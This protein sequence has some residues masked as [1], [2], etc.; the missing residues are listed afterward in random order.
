MAKYVF[1]DPGDDGT[2]VE[3]SFAVDRKLLAP[4]LG[5]IGESKQSIS[6]PPP[7]PYSMRQSVPIRSGSGRLGNGQSLVEIAPSGVSAWSGPSVSIVGGAKDSLRVRLKIPW[8][9][10]GLTPSSATPTIGGS[11]P[12]MAF[13]SKFAYADPWALGVFETV[14]LSPT[15]LAAVATSNFPLNFAGVAAPDCSL[16]GILSAAFS[17][18]RVAAPLRLSYIPQTTTVDPSNFALVFTDDPMHPQVGIGA[19]ASSATGASPPTYS[20]VKNSVNSIVWASWA[21][22]EKEFP[23]DTSTTFY[24]T[25]DL[26]RSISAGGAAPGPVPPFGDVD[27]RFCHF[28]AVTAYANMTTTATT[29]EPK[30]ELFLET[31][32]EFFDFVPVTGPANYP[33]SLQYLLH[34]MCPQPPSARFRLPAPTTDRTSG[35]QV[36]RPLNTFSPPRL[37]R[38]R[39][40]RTKRTTATEARSA[41]P[42]A[43]RALGPKRASAPVLNRKKVLKRMIVHLANNKHRVP[44][45]HHATIDKMNG[46][47]LSGKKGWH[48]PV[49]SAV[50]SLVKEVPVVGPILSEIVGEIGES[51]LGF[52]SNLF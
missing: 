40:L 17:K 37:D 10:I 9:A 50:K 5:A 25:C 11:P 19:Y 6:L 34:C 35:F 30:G 33:L 31:E 41:Q 39:P 42:I 18:Y 20:A 29:F 8:C 32:F 7:P 44:K 49:V 36:G 21:T 12:C 24:S 13:N 22:W 28:G 45:Q 15:V 48:K 23:V 47:A 46:A 38:V 43:R 27:L 2:P 1:V 14:T 51:V 16:I 52:L 3:S 4:E 26:A